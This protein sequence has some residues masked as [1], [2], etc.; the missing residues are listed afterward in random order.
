MC[1]LCGADIEDENQMILHSSAYK[2]VRQT[3]ANLFQT[4]VN[5]KFFM[6]QNPCHVACYILGCQRISLAE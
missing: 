6:S 2:Q 5:A 3:Y 4:A 1:K